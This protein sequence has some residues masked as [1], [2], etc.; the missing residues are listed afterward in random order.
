MKNE[1]WHIELLKVLSKIRLRESL[2]A[3]VVGFNAS[4]HALQ[5]PALPDAFRNPG[6]GPVVAVE[7]ERNVFVKLRPIRHNLGSEPVE[8]RN[9]RAAGILFRLQHQWWH[10]ADQHGH[11]DTF[12]A[13][14]PDVTGNF[15]ATG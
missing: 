6:A 2:D 3:V 1:R 8:D 7:R 4:H 5:P 14:P 15:S 13:M 9:R 12:C 11:S 10:C